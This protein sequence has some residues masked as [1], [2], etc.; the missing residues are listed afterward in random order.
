MSR[1]VK[2]TKSILKKIIEEERQKIKDQKKKIQ[3]VKLS[4]D[5]KKFY[6]L[7]EELKTLLQLKKEQRILFER[8]KNIQMRKKNI[9]KKIKE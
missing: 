1:P 7:R 6:S 9:T 8:I 2:L 5:I 3:E 4:K